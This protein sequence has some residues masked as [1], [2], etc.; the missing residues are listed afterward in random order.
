M[1][2]ILKMAH[3]G[4]TLYVVHRNAICRTNTMRGTLKGHIL[5]QTL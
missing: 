4:Q 1:R 2:G 5:G 3:L